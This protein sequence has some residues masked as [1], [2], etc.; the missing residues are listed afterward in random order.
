MK[1]NS[2]ELKDFDN[3]FYLWFTLFL[4]GMVGVIYVIC[5]LTN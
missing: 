5:L 4:G 1:Q 3:K 2:D